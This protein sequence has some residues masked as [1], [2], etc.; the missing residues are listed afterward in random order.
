MG[1]TL[2]FEFGENAPLVVI[3]GTAVKQK[4]TSQL[5]SEEI[6]EETKLEI[7]GLRKEGEGKKKKQKRGIAENVNK[8]FRRWKS[9]KIGGKIRV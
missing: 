5:L 9:G 7:K 2:L 8:I 1:P 4:P 6:R 3:I